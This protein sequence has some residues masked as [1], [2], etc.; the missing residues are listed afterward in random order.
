MAECRHCGKTFHA[1]TSCGLW[2]TWEYHYHE[3]CWPQSERYKELESV[4]R[5]VKA[6]LDDE[7]RE[8]IRYLIQDNDD[9]EYVMSKVLTEED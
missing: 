6:Q 5:R 1:C 9:A 3:N 7:G 2:W 4:A 8:F